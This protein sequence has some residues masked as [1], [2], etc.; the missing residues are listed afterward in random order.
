M[1]QRYRFPEW[2]Y[3]GPYLRAQ[4]PDADLPRRN[5]AVPISPDWQANTEFDGMIEGEKLVAPFH[6]ANTVEEILAGLYHAGTYPDYWDDDQRYVYPTIQGL[7]ARIVLRLETKIRHKPGRVRTNWFTLALEEVR[8]ASAIFAKGN[9]DSGRGHIQKAH[10]LVEQG[11]RASRRK[12]SF[13]VGVDG[14]AKKL[15]P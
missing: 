14:V 7:L 10:D 11:N 4:D 1:N 15:T 3:G 9:Y 12:L 13:V 6:D 5:P 2:Y 8:L